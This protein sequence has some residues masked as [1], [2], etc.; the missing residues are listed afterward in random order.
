MKNHSSDSGPKAR[1]WAAAALVSTAA[2][3]A[4]AVPGLA[5]A[6]TGTVGHD[7]GLLAALAQGLGHPFTGLDHLTAMVALGVWSGLALKRPLFALAS[8][9]VALLLGA[10]LA[11]S[12]L[13]LPLIEP[14]IAA[15]LLALGLLVMARARLPAAAASALAMGF[16]VFHGAAHGQALAGAQGLAT[17][18]GMA[19][20]TALLLGVG[21]ALSR[22]IAQRSVWMPRLAGAAVAAFGAVLLVPAIAGAVG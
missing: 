2:V 11:A 10:V 22:A 18:L 9:V 21:L 15:S 7:H 13:S 1:V 20:A 6:H 4:L 8:F 5:L 3:A 17:L 16:A 19:A 14:M 12:G